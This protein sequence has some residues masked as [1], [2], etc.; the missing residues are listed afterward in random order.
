MDRPSILV[1][2]FQRFVHHLLDTNQYRRLTLKSLIQALV[3]VE[4]YDCS[5]RPMEI[6]SLW[7]ER[8]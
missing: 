5:S 1:L 3:N 6:V 4:N 7:R 8:I 2:R